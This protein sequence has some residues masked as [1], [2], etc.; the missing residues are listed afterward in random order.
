MCTYG[1]QQKQLHFALLCVHRKLRIKLF[2]L[3]N[4]TKMNKKLTEVT[5]LKRSTIRKHDATICQ[6]TMCYE[7]ED[8]SGS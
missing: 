4:V 7:V 8:P 3:I 1:G 5:A 6:F 2:F